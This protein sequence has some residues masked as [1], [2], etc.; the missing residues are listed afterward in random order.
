MARVALSVTGHHRQ[1][2]DHSSRDVNAVDACYEIKT[3][4]AVNEIQL[5]V[6]HVPR[7]AAIYDEEEGDC[8]CCP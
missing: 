1:V 5:A 7:A 4:A 3:G 6:V 2:A 8:P